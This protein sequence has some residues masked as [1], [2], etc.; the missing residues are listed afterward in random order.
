MSLTAAETRVFHFKVDSYSWA[1][2]VADVGQCFQ[3]E[4]FSVGG[5]EWTVRYYPHGVPFNSR[6]APSIRLVLESLPATV[7]HITVRFGCVQ[8]QVDEEPSVAAESLH[9]CSPQRIAYFRD[10]R[11]LE[12]RLDHGR[13]VAAGKERDCFEVLCKVC[14]LRD[15]I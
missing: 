3:S 1:R 10:E 4:T 5:C 13:L 12:L 7:R 15:P 8:V 2:K 11:S 6:S 14:V 9:M